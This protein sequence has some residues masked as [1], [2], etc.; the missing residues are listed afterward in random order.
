ML[1]LPNSKHKKTCRKHGGFLQARMG[2]RF[3]SQLPIKFLKDKSN[4]MTTKA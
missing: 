2:D 3:Y 1:R 4:I